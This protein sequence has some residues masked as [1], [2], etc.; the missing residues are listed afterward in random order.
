MKSFSA[1]LLCTVVFVALFGCT[2]K[3]DNQTEAQAFLE[4]LFSKD[5]FRLYR[6]DIKQGNILD[7]KSI[8]RVKI[9]TTKEQVAHIL[10]KP[11]LPTLFHEERWD[12]VYYVDS[13]YEKDQFY[14]LVLFFENNQ[15]VRIKRTKRPKSPA[16]SAN[17]NNSR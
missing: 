11:I 14:K 1:F 17:K 6:K 9:G 2:S 13:L 7:Y 10:G 15:V 16:P 12:Y 4:R 3:N 5:T 8:G